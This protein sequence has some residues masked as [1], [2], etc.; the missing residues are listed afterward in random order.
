MFKK[1]IETM[2]KRHVVL[3]YL[4]LVDAHERWYVNLYRR[5][6]KGRGELLAEWP[7]DDLGFKGE[8]DLA[9]ELRL[10]LW[11]QEHGVENNLIREAQKAIETLHLESVLDERKGSTFTT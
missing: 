6:R 9:T 8:M 2:D 4:E 1:K 7:E 5:V 10:R 3:V 11:L